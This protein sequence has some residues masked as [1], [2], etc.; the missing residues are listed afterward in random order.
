MDPLGVPIVM[1]E[2]SELLRDIVPAVVGGSF[3]N[4]RLEVVE[5]PLWKES[6]ARETAAGIEAAAVSLSSSSSN[7][8]SRT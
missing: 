3:D 1:R 5:P 8:S 4:R 2:C 7:S 6:A